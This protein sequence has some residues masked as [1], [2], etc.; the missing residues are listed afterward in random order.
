MFSLLRS[1]YLRRTVAIFISFTL[2]INLTVEGFSQV[3]S[4][5]LPK[6]NQELN[7]SLDKMQEKFL[8]AK[9]S[10]IIDTYSNLTPR[11]YEGDATQ[12]RLKEIQIEV[13]TKYIYNPA[14]DL[15]NQTPQEKLEFGEFSSKYKANIKSEFSKTYKLL[16]KEYQKNREEID[17]AIKQYPDLEGKRQQSYNELDTWHKS[18]SQSLNEQLTNA[19]S[20]VKED[21]D[22]YSREYDSLLEES[23]QELLKDLRALINEYFS[24]YKKNKNKAADT[25]LWVSSDLLTHY[26]LSDNIFT[27]EQIDILLSLFRNKLEE[28]SKRCLKEG[29]CNLEIASIYGLAVLSKDSAAKGPDA[30]LIENFMSKALSSPASTQVASIG[31]ASILSMEGYEAARSFL[32]FATSKEQKK[33]TPDLSF[34]TPVKNRIERNGSLLGPLSQ[35]G[36]YS[37]EG[38]ETGNIWYDIALMLSED[39]S[40]KSL[41][42]L[43]TFGVEKCEFIL[44]KSL[45]GKEKGFIIECDGIAPFL[46]GALAGGKSGA[47]KYT[48]PIKM[49][50]EQFFLEDGSIETANENKALKSQ[51]IADTSKANLDA[52]AAQEGL[53]RAA[54]IAKYFINMHLSDVPANQEKLIDTSILGIYPQIQ[55]ASLGKY[56]VID[57]AR[58]T[59]AERNYKQAKL[60]LNLAKGADIIFTIYCFYDLA[61]L[62]TR[63]YNIIKLSRLKG[64]SRMVFLKN[65]IVAFQKIKAKRIKRLERFN[66]F[67]NHIKIAAPDLPLFANAG[68]K[69]PRPFLGA[70]GVT[71]GAN[72][73]NPVA[74][75]NITGQTLAFAEA[76]APKPASGIIVGAAIDKALKAVTYDSK[77]GA[78]KMEESLMSSKEGKQIHNILNGALARINTTYNHGGLTNVKGSVYRKIVGAQIKSD[79]IKAEIE[80]SA[81][82]GF[83]KKIEKIKELN[84]VPSELPAKTA[85]GKIPLTIYNTLKETL[86]PAPAYFEVSRKIPGIKTKD[87]ASVII[88][89]KENGLADLHILSKN[90]DI[91]KP[92]FFKLPIPES[93]IKN[94]A[95]YSYESSS[96]IPLRLKLAPA[97]DK[98]SGFKN[99][100]HRA[101][102][103]F[104]SKDKQFAA[105]GNFLLERNGQHI[106]TDL[107]FSTSKK[108]QGINSLIRNDGVIGFVNADKGPII[109]GGT[110]NL[111]KKE[112]GNFAKLMESSS[113]KNLAPLNMSIGGSPNKMSTLNYT[114]FISLSA[115]STS[116]ASPLAENFEKIDEKQATLITL[117][118]PYA[119]S[120]FSPLI[121]PFVKRYGATKLLAGSMATASAAT[122][123]PIFFGYHGGGHIHRGNPDNPSIYPLY[124]SAALIGVASALTRSS[125]TPLITQVGG[126]SNTL[127]SMAFKSLSSFVMIT[128]PLFFQMPGYIRGSYKQKKYYTKPDGSYYFS[129]TGK[130]I[131][132]EY[133]DFSFA[134]PILAAMSGLAAYKIMASK[135]PSDIGR[136]KNYK[137][138]S[139]IKDGTKTGALASMRGVLKEGGHSTALLFKKADILIPTATAFM[140]TGAESSILFKYSQKRSDEYIRASG[141]NNIFAPLLTAATIAA[142]GFAVRMSSKS[143]TKLFGGEANPATFRRIFGF[144]LGTA[145][146]GG[147]L[148]YGFK[149]NPA[150]FYTGLALASAGF[151]NATNSALWMGID[152]L[153]AAKFSEEVITSYKTTFPI[154]QL[155]LAAVPML[156]SGNADRMVKNDK[157]LSR[158]DALQ[159]NLWMPMVSMGA[160]GI[161]AART[162]GII[163]KSN[164]KKAVLVATQL[165]ADVTTTFK[166]AALIL[167]AGTIGVTKGLVDGYSVN[168]IN[169][170]A[171]SMPTFEKA[172]EILPYNAKTSPFLLQPKVNVKTPP[173]KVQM[174]SFIERAKQ[175]LPLNASYPLLPKLPGIKAPVTSAQKPQTWTLQ[176]H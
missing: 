151:A 107:R 44:D 59:F 113:W 130:P 81:V 98:V 3:F 42:M 62:G 46:A 159:K 4:Q 148:M 123:L 121:T 135:F 43:R 33:Q 111:P 169:P 35:N 153:K 158:N 175:I 119:A 129:S 155:G 14:Q 69:L 102:S 101:S 30:Y 48:L 7:S 11:L 106:K 157:S 114:S 17:T 31:F 24:I 37:T 128:P 118:F 174:P 126:K 103:K 50:G 49:I 104:I 36:Q 108:Y 100:W 167:P 144:S 116:L 8:Q 6:D 97:G 47:E 154:S 20:N 138:A 12:K 110:F 66:S 65:N 150:M 166:D 94:L 67:K 39:G 143:V 170:V 23:Y 18:A 78:F 28:N 55:K 88:A 147:G 76:A 53:D 87:M 22:A 86:T 164:L 161:L 92:A 80:T 15:G 134:Y 133:L 162:A 95:E 83:I 2:F 132:K 171:P 79:F 71:G 58:F 41:E 19:L 173:L 152:N 120:L 146:L 70:I 64:V 82:P 139:L 57:S 137:F 61:L 60:Y 127:K 54:V 99:I 90:G 68:S 149:D 34:E 156:F 9:N 96:Y 45:L 25:V 1:L 140:M 26:P 136:V 105:E 122:L 160:A 29:Q 172:A 32:A 40:P 124:V 27:D 51:R 91:V 75:K 74:A 73:L 145:A 165:A 131:E 176:N 85:N 142:T 16:D 115:A 72:V 117:S 109:E 141:V 56:A 5:A 38:G 13:F 52:Y 89:T 163:K 93:E 84:F 10:P 77:A 112:L 125:F 21:Y 168:G 63:I